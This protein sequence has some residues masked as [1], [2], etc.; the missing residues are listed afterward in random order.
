[1]RPSVAGWND[2]LLDAVLPL[3][4]SA[5]QPVLFCCTDESVR[6]AG[7]RL[8]VD[9]REAMPAFVSACV[10][11]WGIGQAR[12]LSGVLG[13]IL[14]FREAPRP[15]L[16]PPWLSLLALAVVA[17]THMDN[18]ELAVTGAYYKR[19]MEML[20]LRPVEG[21][22]PVRGFDLLQPLWGELG[23]WLRVDAEGRR[24]L[25]V[26]PAKPKRRHVDYPISQ[27]LLRQ[28][29][30]VV[31][32]SFVERHR[33][34]IVAGFDPVRLLRTWG[35]RH[36]L[37]RHARDLLDDEAF[38]PVLRAALRN[39]A[40][41]WDGSVGIELGARGWP[42]ELRLAAS[43]RRIGLAV[44][45]P[46]ATEA[47]D[48]E[49]P[50]GPRTLPAYPLELSVPLAWL[51]QLGRGA[52]KLP[53]SGGQD[54][55][56]VPGGRTMIFELTERGL[57]RVEGAR[58][59]HVWLLSCEPAFQ[60][61]EF[62][63]CRYS[64][65]LLPAGWSLLADV[66]PDRLL[67]EYRRPERSDQ[68][69]VRLVGGLHLG[70]HAY[71]DGY[72]PRI[73]VGALEDS[74][75][76]AFDGR[77]IGEAR[78]HSQFKLTDV[79]PGSHHV[80]VGDLVEFPFEMTSRGLREAA[81]LKW[82]L[83]DPPLYRRGAA[84]TGTAGRSPRGPFVAGASVSGV[85][86]PKAPSLVLLRTNATV[87]VVGSDG[88]IETCARPQPPGWLRQ[89]GLPA[90]L[91]RWRVPGGERAEW[92]VLLGAHTR[93][94]VRVGTGTVA[95]SEELADVAAMADDAP[96]TDLGG[97]ADDAAAAEWARVRD[98][99]EVVDDAG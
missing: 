4:P 96:V 89:M 54:A 66:S 39:A 61:V 17:A 48:V 99:C 23:D 13:D 52:L 60:A 53:I 70:E 49:S 16:V 26:I 11:A 55:V 47:K 95:P 8:G 10:S 98:A 7:S 81:D 97:R 14:R 87:Y 84:A 74:V 69:D 91:S 36:S 43:P 63:D 90:G 27:T 57:L 41:T 88:R 12:G 78:P 3:G 9:S 94:V 33:A 58:D 20:D 29:D 93:R 64:S 35:G 51:D 65:S 25:L 75:A 68:P 83:G 6:L 37:T 28:R 59:E 15:R 77:Q 80:L 31:L 92:L 44:A 79:P 76:V 19:L 86:R 46:G 24:G 21:H 38:A 62:D 40:A 82:D 5:A 73:A 42:A 85:D 22:P 45:L 34:N 50:D 72:P 18:D 67:S 32:G 2:A 30:N 71:L 56:V 1:M